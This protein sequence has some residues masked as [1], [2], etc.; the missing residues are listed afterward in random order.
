[1]RITKATLRQQASLLPPS[2]DNYLCQQCQLF[3]T[4]SHPF[5]RETFLQPLVKLPNSR[6]LFVTSQPSVYEA[7]QGKQFSSFLGKYFK[8]HILKSIGLKPEQ[9]AFVSAIACSSGKTTIASQVEWCRAFVF[10]TIAAVCPV[11]IILLGADAARSVLRLKEPVLKDLTN[12]VH[13][14]NV[15]AGN[16]LFN[17]P[18]IVTY[19]L[20]HILRDLSIVGVIQTHI[21]HFIYDKMEVK[22]WKSMTILP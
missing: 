3:S 7:V 18:A 9:C 20:A 22:E 4:C 17:I 6:I 8:T 15:D 11:K 1:M 10:Q 21:E 16:N 13:I 14:V 12:R 2:Q 19:G 5:L